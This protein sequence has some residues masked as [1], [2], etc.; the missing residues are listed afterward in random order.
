M[1]EWK[2]EIDERVS[3]ALLCSLRQQLIQ[4]SRN[5]SEEIHQPS[6]HKKN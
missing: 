2:N 3:E 1:N 6:G 5:F 4:H